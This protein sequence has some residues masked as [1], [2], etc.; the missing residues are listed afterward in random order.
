MEAEATIINLWR[1]RNHESMARSR[2]KKK[3]A[4][5][6]AERSGSARPCFRKI[7]AYKN[8]AEKCFELYF[9]IVCNR[10]ES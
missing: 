1:A 3:K 8:Y 6:V 5:H 2:A 9:V 4:K 10:L 7:C